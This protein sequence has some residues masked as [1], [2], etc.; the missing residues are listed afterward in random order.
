MNCEFRKLED[1]DRVGF[2][3]EL[4]GNVAK[5][6]FQKKSGGRVVY[7]FQNTGEIW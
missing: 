4:K 6:N 7:W 1:R 2:E 5:E 3:D